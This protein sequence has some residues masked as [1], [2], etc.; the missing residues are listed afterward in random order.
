MQLRGPMNRLRE[1]I[2]AGIGLGVIAS[3]M[4][5]QELPLQIAPV[6]PVAL[7]EPVW[8]TPNLEQ[9]FASF[10]ECPEGSVKFDD[11]YYL[12]LQHGYIVAL[13]AWHQA[14]ETQVRPHV[15]GVEGGIRNARAARLMRVMV[16]LRLR[17]NPAVPNAAP[18]IGRVTLVL[19]SDWGRNAAGDVVD[20]VLFGTE[21]GFFV[22]DVLAGGIRPY[23]ATLQ[24]ATRLLRI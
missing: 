20:L 1:L 7:A 6:P 10:S 18:L 22:A 21:Q 24:R 23:D 14:I 3:V 5:A 12:R 19:P 11:L 16:G 13:V 17:D 8:D 9:V 15:A 2:R 4:T